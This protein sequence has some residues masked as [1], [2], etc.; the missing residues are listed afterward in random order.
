MDVAIEQFVA[1]LHDPALR[2]KVKTKYVDVTKG[3]QTLKGVYEAAEGQ[4][5]VLK[6]KE[7]DRAEQLR[8]DNDKELVDLRN[9]INSWKPGM[10]HQADEAKEIQVRLAKLG[11]DLSSF[12]A[13]SRPARQLHRIASKDRIQDVTNTEPT[14]NLQ[15]Y[16]GYSPQDSRGQQQPVVLA[17]AANET[18]QPRE[19]RQPGP[20]LIIRQ[21]QENQAFWLIRWGHYNRI[22]N[23]LLEY[24]RDKHETPVALEEIAQ[25]KLKRPTGLPAPAAPPAQVAAITSIPFNTQQPAVNA[26]Y[27]T[28]GTGKCSENGNQHVS[29]AEYDE[30]YNPDNFVPEMRGPAS[31]LVQVE[32]SDSENEQPEV[33][34][35]ATQRLLAVDSITV[36]AGSEYDSESDAGQSARVYTIETRGKK[37]RMKHDGEASDVEEEP[38]AK[39]P[40]PTEK[41]PA[42][43]PAKKGGKRT[44][45]SIDKP[46]ELKKINALKDKPP[47]EFKRLTLAPR[48]PRKKQASTNTEVSRVGLTQADL[49][50][51]KPGIKEMTREWAEINK[52]LT[53]FGVPVVLQKENGS[54]RYSL[55]YQH[56][57]ADQGSDLV[58]IDSKLAH[59]MGLKIHHTSEF[60]KHQITMT[61]ASGQR[62]V[63]SH[64]VMLNINAEG[65]KRRLFAFVNPHAMG[66]KLLLGL[67]WLRAVKA[68]LDIAA[69]TITIGDKMLDESPII[70]SSPRLLDPRPADDHKGRPRA[71]KKS[72]EHIDTNN[73]KVVEGAVPESTFRVFKVGLNE[74]TSYETSPTCRCGTEYACLKHHEADA[75]L[76][77]YRTLQ[78]QAILDGK[79]VECGC[80]EGIRCLLHWD[81]QKERMEEE[82]EENATEGPH[83][84]NTALGTN[85]AVDNLTST[86]FPTQ[87]RLI[88]RTI[89][90][91]QSLEFLEEWNKT[92]KIEIGRG[93]PDSE[94]LKFLQL[95]WTYRD[96]TANDIAEVPATDLITHR[97]HPRQGLKPYVARQPR[98]TNDREWRLREIIQKGIDA[99][100]GE[101]RLVFNYHYIYEDPQGSTME[102]SRKVQEMMSNPKWK[103]FFGADMKHGYWG[104]PVHPEDRHY[105]AFHIPG[106]GQLQPTRMPQ[107]TRTSSFT[108]TELMNI[109]LGAIPPPNPEPSLLHNADGSDPNAGFY[110]DDIFG[111]FETWQQLYDFLVQQF[112][113]RLGSIDKIRNWP[114]PQDKT[115]VR[116]FMGVVNVTRKWISNFN[117]IARPLQRQQSKTVEWKWTES[118]EL[119]FLTLKKLATNVMNMFGH[120]P[121]L[122]VEA[123]TDA[124]KWGT[125]IYIR[126]L[127]NGEMRPILFDSYN[128]TPTQR[129]YDTYK[130]ELFAIVH[131]T[132]KH[133][134]YFNAKDTS[135]IHTDH[136]PLVGFMNA[137]EHEDIYARWANKLRM[138]NIKLKY[139]EGEKNVV[140]DSLSRVIYNAEDCEPDQ[141][142]KDLYQEAV[143]HVDDDEWFW[144]TGKG[145]YR[146]M[147][148]KL[149]DEDRKKRIEE[150]G[151]KVS[152]KVYQTTCYERE[153]SSTCPIGWTTFKKDI[154]S[155]E[156]EGQGVEEDA[157]RSLLTTVTANDESEA[158]EPDYINDEWY[159][160]IYKYYAWDQAPEVDKATMAAFKRK[161]NTYRYDETSKRLLHKYKDGYCVCLQKDEIAPLLQEVHDEAGHFSTNIVLARIKGKV[162]WPYMASDVK[163]Y[164]QGCMECALWAPAMRTVPLK[165]IQ[166]YQ[167]YDLF[168]IDFID[169]PEPSKY[170]Y[171]HICNMV[172]YFS[173]RLFPYPTISTK[174]KDVKQ[175]FEYHKA[176]GHPMPAAAYW[177]ADTA[178]QSSEMAGELKDLNI[179]PIQAPSQSH[180]S[181]GVIE[182]ANRILREAMNKMKK[183]DE[184]F[185][186]TLRRAAPACNERHIEHLGYSPDEIIFGVEP[187]APAT[188]SLVQA[189]IRGEKTVLP[190]PEEMT[191]LIWDHMARRE[192]LRKDVVKRTGKA[193]QR[194]KERYDAGVKQ[195][196]YLPGQIVF[197]RD[198]NPIHNKAEPRWNGPFV[199]AGFGGEHGSSYKLRTLENKSAPNTHHGDQLRV[200]RER[201][202]YLRKANEEDLPV[203]RNLR[204]TRRKVMKRARKETAKEQAFRGFVYEDPGRR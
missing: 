25:T 33:D 133:E 4:S 1:G 14:S 180:K 203:M 46:K 147:L 196:E 169:W 2:R 7:K 78:A 172:D 20:G 19:R 68:Q 177:D 129:S 87:R 186:D 142:V 48:K 52:D 200:F 154:P 123:F 83:V 42:T 86:S 121:N 5:A 84:N 146:D 45:K 74:V 192:E 197:L 80:S 61:V 9:A 73:E 53:A 13:I 59:D 182:R 110:I 124:S 11:L 122:P 141:L 134:H 181:V 145:G 138:H 136:K 50:T 104:V 185:V 79:E 85:A 143:K 112:F 204:R 71:R 152:P 198:S 3:F 67:P 160:D 167:P 183:E 156:A 10:H 190:T 63:L 109:L 58:L 119:A 96:A 44:K 105:L 150:Y 81:E 165:P 189:A 54:T 127:Q 199:I 21:Q 92:Q 149:S 107:G 91:S 193:K 8:V 26:V 27:Y 76:H 195:Q 115:G 157:P 99:G 12:A 117:E 191:S 75:D 31:R 140:A 168:G 166:T 171:K 36:S 108:F 151:D 41:T 37:R 93:I 6:S 201:T 132:G 18:I 118:E 69:K 35:V 70:I 72:E 38:A 120:D 89:D 94:R 188:V 15:Q 106:I 139:I 111:G 97:V 30:V 17:A 100:I 135:I 16:S 103:M 125:G 23:G 55:G 173:G 113:P 101:D 116:G 43:A 179:V 60:V 40:E 65:I 187:R 32:E 128:F 47:D 175:A 62:K 39:S 66:T 22:I 174:T 82:E 176:S 64:W 114:V 155:F 130:K 28:Y 49:S 88:R 162:Y 184:D 178:F 131:F 163:A 24:S 77:E 56:A 34:E 29:A 144:K 164:V 95:A 194:M 158:V 170:G 148:K 51:L 161:V 90:E 126:Q 202:G 102:L 137:K 98:L 57:K 153:M 159:S